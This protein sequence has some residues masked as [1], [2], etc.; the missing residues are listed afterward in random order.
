MFDWYA[1][2]IILIPAIVLGIYAQAK[3]QS[4]FRKYSRIPNSLGLTGAEAARRM[5]E[6][7]GVTDV[8]I[9]PTTG[10]LSDYYN[11]GDKSLNLS[12]E[13]YEAR[14]IAAVGVACHEAGHALQHARGYF[15][16]AVR[17][18]L[19]P[20]AQLGSHLWLILFFIGL[21]MHSGTL[22][23]AGIFIYA[24]AVVF[25]I[26]TLPVEFNAS[27]RAVRALADSSML[28][29]EELQGVK[30]VLG[31]A[32]LTYVA[33]ALMAILQLLRLILLAQRRS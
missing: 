24:A 22:M 19:V 28:L 5:L 6:R 23:W 21:F 29:P 7:E 17:S 2:M 10:F 8:T 31:A 27:G 33:A 9:R 32:A 20:A 16:L 18:A 13:V 4:A 12:P 25:T 1:S 3:V 11:P 15:P 26:V 30:K 14:T